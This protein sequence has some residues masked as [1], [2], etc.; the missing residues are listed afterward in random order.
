[1]WKVLQSEL[2]FIDSDVNYRDYSIIS[3]DNIAINAD[4]NIAQAMPDI[5]TEIVNP[6]YNSYPIADCWKLVGYTGSG[7][8]MPNIKHSRQ[9]I[10]G[11]IPEVK[12]CYRI[13]VDGAGVTNLSQYIL[14]QPIEKG[15]SRYCLG[16]KYL[17]ITFYARS[18]IVGK[19]IRPSITL[20]YGTGGSPSSADYIGTNNNFAISLNTNWT[21]YAISYPLPDFSTKTFGTND[22]DRLDIRL[23]LA[24]NIQNFI[25]SG[26]IEFAKV[27][28][29]CDASTENIKP[30][31]FDEDLKR[32]MRYYQKTY[33]YNV[34]PST[35]NFVNGSLIYRQANVGTVAS[36]VYVNFKEAMYSRPTITFY[37]PINNNGNW[38]NGG[39]KCD[40]AQALSAYVSETGFFAHNSQ[41]ASDN[42][43]SSEMLVHWVA[44]CRL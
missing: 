29:V 10:S 30:V 4:F 20:N 44:D 7:D 2:G 14:I 35:L 9:L 28:V 25:G 31:P 34:T 33:A 41:L 40:S 37:N 21:K 38:Y 16:K 3:T 32:C 36:G 39:L 18:T 19:K 15:V 17:N 43:N 8:A 6:S 5:A 13:N 42:V 27:R 26:Y 1:M 11:I 23:G 24:D 22:D 12:Y